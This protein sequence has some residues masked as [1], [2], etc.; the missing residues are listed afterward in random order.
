MHFEGQTLAI[1]LV[2][3]SLMLLT[4]RIFGEIFTKL[5]QPSVIG[6]ILA[7]IILG[8]TIFGT[9]FPNQ[10]NIFFPSEGEVKIGIDGLT[11]L[12]VILLLLVSGM[13]VDLTVVISNRKKAFFTSVLGI[14]IP[15]ITG[16]LVAYFFPHLMGIEN[17]ETKLIFALFMGTALSISALPVIAKTLMDLNIFKSEIGF[18]IISAAML[19]DII[20]WLIFSIILGMMGESHSNFSFGETLLYTFI[21]IIIVLLFL[22]RLINQIINW[23]QEKLSFP[24]A[25]LNF[26]IILGLIGA[27]VTQFI[28]IHAVL[29]AF[30]IGVSIGE[31]EALKE[32]TR[33]I[34]NQFVTNIFAPL[35]FVSIGLG[36]NFIS[37]F[38]LNITLIILMLAILGKVFGSY[39]G[40]KI[41]G[42]NKNDSLLVGF[43]MNSR[44]TMEIIL[45]LL[46]FNSGIINQ[47]V[48]VA[49]VIMALV[50]SIASGPAMNYL[51][52]KRKG[53]SLVDLIKPELFIFTEKKSKEEII[54]ELCKIISEKYNLNYEDIFNKV[55]ER[56]NESS[57]GIANYLA[58]PH[59]RFNIENPILAIAM[60]KDGVDF[61]ALDETK[62]K[63]IFLLLTPENNNELQLQ[64]LANIV[65]KFEN[66]ETVEKIIELQEKNK[67]INALK[68]IK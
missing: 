65:N 9:L 19:N 68:S 48:F 47:S 23:I 57:S 16:F 5:N 15:F 38:D 13:E 53:T 59:A 18:I 8:P 30:I 12:S 39:L 36:V 63:F 17:E 34:I 58:I 56:E 32:R 51:L 4:A 21:F 55:M 1:F 61:N 35:F 27:V 62:T 46:A 67:I 40:A 60:N 6:E 25:I 49:L 44:G 29:G 37:N 7:G 33:E 54:S 20:G 14:V 41:G 50:T 52:K 3:I 2:S 64:L 42:L 22:R 24:S 10:F 45:G 66:K 43:G 11:N 28:G 26:L 31:S